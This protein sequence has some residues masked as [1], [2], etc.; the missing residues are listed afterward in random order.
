MRFLRFPVSQL[1][2]AL[3]LSF[4]VLAVFT[5]MDLS[6]DPQ[7]S[8][9]LTRIVGSL[10]TVGIILLLGRTIQ[11]G[12]LERIG[13]SPRGASSQIMQGVLVGALMMGSVTGL[14]ALMGWCKIVDVNFDMFALGRIL[15]LYLFAA[16]FEELLFRGILF[17][18]LDNVFGSWLALIVSGVLFGA[19]HLGNPNATIWTTLALAISAGAGLGAA[20]LVTR[21]V[22]L[23]V[24]LHWA[25]NF[26]LAMFG[27]AVSGL[28]PYSLLTVTIN[29]P[30]LWSGGEFGIEVGLPTLIAAAFAS[31]G[32]LW[33][34]ARRKHLSPPS[35]S[36]R[37]EEAL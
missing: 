5:V 23:A 31:A 21:N 37:K 11:G 17:R 16:L 22:W 7:F 8:S 29:A 18:Q 4:A 9:I 2:L 3:I 33:V 14:M 30:A 26:L 34:A 13:I 15:I 28:E 32:M 36:R 10:L 19:T 24:G 1:I 12:T 27:F 25:W 6:T 20:Y 35:W